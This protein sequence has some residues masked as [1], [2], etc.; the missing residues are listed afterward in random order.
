MS[1]LAP[2]TCFCLMLALPSSARAELG[3]W[4]RLKDPVQGNADALYRALD[5]GRVPRPLPG[6]AVLDGPAAERLHN[7]ATAVKILLSG[8]EALPHSDLKYLLALCAANGTPE[9]IRQ[10]GPALV[11]ALTAAPE[12]PLAADAWYDLGIVSEWADELDAAEEA[13]TAALRLEW[14]REQRA[15]IYRMR[16]QLQMRRGQLAKAIEDYSMALG[17]SRLAELRALA[18]WGLAVALDRSHDFPSSVAYALQAYGARFGPQARISVID[19]DVG[20]IWPSYD[21]HYYRGLALLAEAT[22]KKG[23]DGYISTLLA[24]QLMWVRYLDDAPEDGPWVTRA[25]EH[26]ETVRHALEELDDE[27]DEDLPF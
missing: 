24:S 1:R 9:T 18:K 15:A 17:E 26:L 4:Q 25:R 14:D 11:A 5:A 13:Y 16:G 22:K 23:Q 12:H 10:A 3:I 8:G 19:L 6:G 7:G 27:D 21:E 20:H 2:V